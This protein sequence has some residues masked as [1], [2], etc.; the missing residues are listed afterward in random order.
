MVATHSTMLPLGTPCPDFSLKDTE[1]TT[2]SL[3]SFQDAPALV[4]MFICN[5]C[6]YVMHIRAALANLAKEYQKKPKNILNGAMEKNGKH[7]I[8][9][10]V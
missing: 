3:D 9:V 7:L 1:E 10:G 6:P 5:H 2:I 4:I 8:T